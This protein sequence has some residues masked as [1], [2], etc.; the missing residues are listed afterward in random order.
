MRCGSHP[1]WETI[2]CCVPE[3]ARDRRQMLE[4]QWVKRVWIQ[5][6]G[7]DTCAHERQRKGAR[8]L[9]VPSRGPRPRTNLASVLRNLMQI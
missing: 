4:A 5:G 3:V 1:F 9:R 6:D 7:H 2:L 8:R